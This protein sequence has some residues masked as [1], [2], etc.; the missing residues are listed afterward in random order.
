MDVSSGTHTL[1]GKSATPA[2]PPTDERT[3]CSPVHR[4]RRATSAGAARP[5]VGCAAARPSG[6]SAARTAAPPISCPS[7]LDA[8][9]PAPSAGCAVPSREPLRR[10]RRRGRTEVIALPGPS[11]ESTL[12]DDLAAWGKVLLLETRGRHSGLPRRVALGFIDP[13]DGSLL[14]AASDEGTRTGPSTS[15]PSRAASSQRDGVASPCRASRVDDGR[16]G[17][18]WPRSS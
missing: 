6:S 15:S 3:T 2:A 8:T 12:D 10:A 17:R 18:R 9:R 16:S 1:V 13:G 14:V 4:A 5:S 11:D 7:P